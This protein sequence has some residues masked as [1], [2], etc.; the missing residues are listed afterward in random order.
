MVYMAK[1]GFWLGLE[2]MIFSVTG[3]LLAIAFAN[4]LPK[5]TYGIY[6]YVLSLA[7]ILSIPTLIGMNEAL[8]LSIAKG[9]EGSINTAIKTRL[10]WGFL[11][12]VASVGVAGYYFINGNITLTMAFLIVAIFI[13]PF[14]AFKIYRAIW[15]GK[16]LFK[17]FTIFSA[18][19]QILSV[20]ALATTLF[21]TDNIF[22][23]FLTYFGSFTVLHFTA[24]KLTL[25]QAS[26]NSKQDPQTIP[27]GKHLSL[28]S[29]LGVVTKNLDQVLIWYFLGAVSVAVYYFAIIGPQQI[30]SFSKIIASLALPK[31]S[32]TIP[33]PE[34]KIS[35][36]KK[37]FA[38]LLLSLVLVTVYIVFSPIFYKLILPQYLDSLPY[39]QVFSLSIV[40][41]VPQ[42]L[43]QAFFTSLM[44]IKALY[45]FTSTSYTLR[46]ILPLFLLPFY[47]IW[48]AIWAALIANVLT[49]LLLF[50][51]VRRS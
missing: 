21:L 7:T 44:K 8:I 12:G 31:F 10:R 37:T 34:L 4:L 17:Y 20:A 9:S 15:I 27:Y 14:E 40:F 6:R 32:R 24:L 23:L 26:L 45:L 25:K 48:G 1:G 18:S 42:I 3:F 11:G 2:Q 51:L 30:I 22:F 41:L 13:S 35:V 39:S 46:I 28:M 43:L 36:L 19:I 49:F 16:K 29:T 33:S 50:F 38:L 5:E 47:G